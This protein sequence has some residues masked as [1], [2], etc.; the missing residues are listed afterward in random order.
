MDR[1]EGVDR[2]RA[3]AAL[4]VMLAHLL[5]PYLPG[6]LKYLFTGHPAVIA[7]FVISGFCIHYPFLNR[8]LPVAAFLAARAMRILPPVLV[9]IAIAYLSGVRKYN[10]VEGY[11]LWSVVCELWYYALYPAFLALSR[12]VAWHWQWAISFVASLAVVLSIGSDQYGNAHVYGPFLNWVVGLP[13]WIA[14]CVI[15]TMMGKRPKVGNVYVWRAAV[16]LTASCLYWLTLN[17]SVGY[18]LTMNFFAILVAAWM[19]AEIQHGGRTLFDWVGKWSFSIYLWHVIAVTWIAA[20]PLLEVAAALAASY[21]AYLLVEK[22]AHRLARAVFA[23]M[24]GRPLQ[25]S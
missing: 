17:T 19:L 2:M 1:V 16:A 7:F 11:I 25:R 5:G 21:I 22:P 24:R 18:Y 9:A 13:S 8:P 10:F 15:A 20:H 4:S 12:Y 3:F 23:A 6:P 14:G